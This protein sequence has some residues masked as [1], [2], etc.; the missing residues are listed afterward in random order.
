MEE[1]EE[2]LKKIENDPDYEK[3]C[4]DDCKQAILERKETILEFYD[5]Y[6]TESE[7]V[8]EWPAAIASV[9]EYGE[10]MEQLFDSEE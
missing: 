1:M 3:E 9:K 6:V 8:Q 10:K 2:Y 5:D 7:E 4:I